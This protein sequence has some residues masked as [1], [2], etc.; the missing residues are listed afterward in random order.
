M[1][2][3]LIDKTG[4]CFCTCAMPC[5]VNE[6]NTG[7]SPRCSQEQIE[8]KGFK[9]IQVLGDDSDKAVMDA[10]CIDGKEHRLKIRDKIMGDKN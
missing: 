2:L 9:T 4:R 6:L 1:S 3:I 8:N 7:M 5:V 10:I